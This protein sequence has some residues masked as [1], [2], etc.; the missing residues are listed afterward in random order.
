MK[1]KV[2]KIT[3]AFALLAA[4]AGALTACGGVELSLSFYVD[5]ER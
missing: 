4:F 1:G 3:A 2:I 5:G